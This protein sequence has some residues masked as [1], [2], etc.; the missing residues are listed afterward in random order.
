M[1]VCVCA[2]RGRAVDGTVDEKD[3]DEGM[4]RHTKRPGAVS[5]FF[6]GAREDISNER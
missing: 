1:C 5:F 4:T 2:S 3:L 6:G